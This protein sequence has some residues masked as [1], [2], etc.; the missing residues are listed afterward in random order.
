MKTKSAIGQQ[1]R[2][3]RKCNEAFMR[4]WKLTKGNAS[5]KPTRKVL[6]HWRKG[7]GLAIRYNLKLRDLCTLPPEN[8]PHSEPNY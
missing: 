1:I 5:D 7:Y 8:T 4:V 6:K 2:I 3:V